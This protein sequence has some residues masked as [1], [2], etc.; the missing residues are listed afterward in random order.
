MLFLVAAA[1][2]GGVATA[3]VL[4]PVS[5]FAALVTAPL[6]ASVMAVLAAVLMAWRSGRDGR[7]TPN[8][9]AQTDA[10]VVALRTLTEQ[11]GTAPA[12]QV[13]ADRPRVA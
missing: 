5:P 8:L 2:G 12:A 4:G 11:A 7:E 10:M 3:A 1:L 9:D 6:M 13:P